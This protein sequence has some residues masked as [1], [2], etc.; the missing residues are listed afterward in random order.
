MTTSLDL[1]GPLGAV[2]AVIGFAA[3]VAPVATLAWCLG[4]AMGKGKRS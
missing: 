1:T 3:V 4:A 2:F